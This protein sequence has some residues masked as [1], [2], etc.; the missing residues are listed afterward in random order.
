MSGVDLEDGTCNGFSKV[1]VILSYIS[2]FLLV[3]KGYRCVHGKYILDTVRNSAL[4]LSML[5]NCVRE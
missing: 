5:G 3:C 4:R 2:F 1:R